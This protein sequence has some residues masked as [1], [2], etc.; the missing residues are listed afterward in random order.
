MLNGVF[1]RINANSVSHIS[2]I[3]AIVGICRIVE[4]KSRARWFFVIFSGIVTMILSH[5]RSGILGFVAAL[6]LVCFLNKRRRLFIVGLFIVIAITVASGSHLMIWDYLSR[7]Q[8]VSELQTLGARIYKWTYA[9]GHLKDAVITGYGAYSGMEFLSL[10]GSNSPVG[11]AVHSAWVRLLAGTGIV[12]ALP[13][14]I[15]VIVTWI[16]LFQRSL[17][18]AGV[19][20]AALSLESLAVLTVLFIRSI[21]TVKITTHNS[22]GFFV[23][24]GIQLFLAKRN[25]EVEA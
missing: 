8:S 23:A 6:G 3:L 17:A 13:V 5:G 14:L 11:L 4:G 15:F 9:W 2:G 10:P 22:F 25:Q 21:F 12:G 24:V 16:K 18:P 19:E 7:G 1:P 20:E